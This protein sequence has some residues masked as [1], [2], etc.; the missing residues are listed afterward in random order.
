MV[1]ASEPPPISITDLRSACLA[2]IAAL[3]SLTLGAP[4][5]I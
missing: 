5:E 2:T 1:T 4:I 3:E